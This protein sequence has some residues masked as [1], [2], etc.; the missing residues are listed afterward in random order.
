[1]TWWWFF[2]GTNPFFRIFRRREKDELLIYESEVLTNSTNPSWK[3]FRM[4]ESKLC[5]NDD[6]LEVEIRF[7]SFSK[8][9]NHT[10]IGSTT[11]SMKKLGETKKLKIKNAQG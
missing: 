10:S 5:K 4:S 3:P 2:G 1:M 11:F 8:R 7:Y 9:G 6:N